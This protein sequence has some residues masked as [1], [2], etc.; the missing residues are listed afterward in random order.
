MSQ[1]TYRTTMQQAYEGGHGQ[2][3]K[4]VTIRNNSGAEITYGHAVVFDTGAGT[5]EIAAKL[6]SALADVVM[7]ALLYEH[8]HETA[9]GNG[10]PDDG[11]GS[12][13]SK[14]EIWMITEQAV[15]PADPVFVRYVLAGATGTTPALGQVRKDADTLKAA[16][17]TAAR[18]RT[19]A[20][21][22]ALV[23]VEWNLP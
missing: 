6:P 10:I 2:L 18:F 12:V 20:A 11:V 8:S 5:T 7:G 1:L 23:L 22:G 16:P 19:V 15:T 13:V 21:A 3:E 9:N 14:G 17:V 4:V